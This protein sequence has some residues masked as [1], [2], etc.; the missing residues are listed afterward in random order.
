MSKI[1]ATDIDINGKKYTNNPKVLAGECQF[2]FIHKGDIHKECVKGQKGKWCATQLN[3]DKKA[4]KIG[5]CPNTSKQKTP[6]QKKTIKQKTLKKKTLK[7]KIINNIPIKNIVSASKGNNTMKNQNSLNQLPV[8]VPVGMEK[9]VRPKND[10]LNISHWENPNRKQFISWFDKSFGKYRIKTQEKKPIECDLGDTDCK[11]VKKKRDLF[12]TQKIVRDYMNVNSPYRGILLYHGLGVGKS[13]A[14]IAIAESNKENRKV[15]ILLQVSIKQNYIGELMKC[16]DEYFKLNQHWVFVPCSSTQGR[17]KYLFALKIGITKSSI[18]VNNGAF[19]IDF[20]KT[21]NFDSLSSIEREKI[22]LQ[23]MKMIESKYDFKHTNGLTDKQLTKMEEERYFDNKLVIIDEVHNIINGMTGGGSMRATR[24]NALFMDA[25]NVRFVFLSG[26]PM[27]NIPFEIAKIFNILR[28]NII[29][30]IL[31]LTLGKDRT[32]IDWQELEE[33]LYKHPLVDQVIIDSRN[34]VVK[35]NRNPYGFVNHN[36]GLV[37]SDLNEITD[38]EFVEEVSNY[39]KNK[40]RYKVLYIDKEN[41]TTFP[42]DGKQFSEMFYDAQK[43]DIKDK[44]LFKRRTLGMTSYVASAKQHLVPSIRERDVLRIPMSDY[45]FNQYA[46]VRKGEIEKDKKSKTK[47]KKVDVKKGGDPKGDIFSINSS[48]RTYSRMACQFAF[49]EKMERPFKGDLQDVEYD[50]DSEVSKKIAE[51]N[52]EYEEKI[53]KA[54]KTLDKEKLR[55]ELRLKIK[56]VHGKSKEY[57][58]RIAAVLKDLDDNREEYLIYDNGNPEKLMKYSTKYAKIIERLLRDRG[59]KEKGLK[60]IY[61]EYKTCEGIGILSIVLKANGYSPFKIKKDE[62]GEW[63]LDFDPETDKLPK[64]AVWEGK[65]ESD[66]ILKIYNDHLE[67]LP[68]KIRDQVKKINS[69]NKRGEILEILMTTKQ[70]AEGL[71]TRHVRQLHVVEPYWNP[72]RLDQVIGR[73]VRTNSHM[74]LPLKDRNVDIYIY[75]SKAKNSQ[76]KRDVTISNDF[77]GKTS[78]EALYDIAERK[79]DI[80]NIIL[81]IIKEGAIDCSLNLTDNIQTDKNI[82]CINFGDIKTRKNFSY[83]ADIRNE[84]KEKERATRVKTQTKKA[85][86]KKTKTGF[87]FYIIGK[88]MYDYD[89]VKAGRKG[90]PIGEVITKDGKE[91]IKPYKKL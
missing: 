88:Y 60:F 10:I 63:E 30:Y 41:T 20:T 12:T 35:F 79:R 84:V 65:E 50:E 49:P 7:E 8:D 47:Q 57:E 31:T 16:G 72:I 15:V 82:R 51:L 45:M 75:L 66:I 59:S 18:S 89:A 48:Y 52:S 14:S 36:N 73:A 26:T 76:L 3:K 46:K 39:V 87:K 68:D 24:L 61:T 6:K 13:C 70:G 33:E 21:S 67:D 81:R 11:S 2:P 9:Y 86:L 54:K 37:K 17:D 34:K 25:I 83:K 27:M 38:A 55:A 64:Y 4:I 77:D 53:Y 85:K 69:T 91:L 58:R 29:N 43:N 22:R 56:E 42:D 5:F 40:L 78:D 44:E 80:M 74:E 19:F 62:N 32:R 1:F 71:N 90:E 23:I 28:G